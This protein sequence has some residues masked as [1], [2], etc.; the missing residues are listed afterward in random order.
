ML[1]MLRPLATLLFLLGLCAAQ[2]QEICD[3]ALDDDND[4]LIDLNDTTDCSCTGALGGSEEVNSII[5]NP[6]FE[7]LDCCPNALEQLYCA[8]T[9]E[10]ATEPTTDF[11]HECGWSPDVMPQPLPDGLGCV[12]TFFVP[13]WQE[14]VG[15]CLLSPMLAGQ[16]YT[17]QFDVAGTMMDNWVENSDPPNLSETELVLY[18]TTTCPTFPEPG[19]GCPIGIGD[20]QVLASVPYTPAF[21]W[22]QIEMQFTPT[23]EVQAVMLGGPCTLPSDYQWDFASYGPYLLWDDLIM[24]ASDQF[25]SSIAMS[26]S[27]CT[28]DLTLSA[29][30]D[31][32][33]GTYQWFSEGVALVGQVDTVLNLS[34]NGL[35]P[36]T[37]QFQF[38]LDTSCALSTITVPPIP[39]IPP[40]V[41]ASDTVG[42]IPLAVNFSDVTVP[43]VDSCIW[44]FGDNTPSVVGCDVSHTY[45]TPGLYDVTLTIV[46]PD[47]CSYDSTYTDLIHAVGPPTAGFDVSPQPVVV[48]SGI[49]QLSSTSSADA[50]SW[51]W[52][53]GDLPPFGSNIENPEVEVPVVPGAF[54]IT[55][56]VANSYGCIDTVQGMMVVVPS[57]DL[58]MPNVFS[59]NGDTE[60]DRFIPLDD[61]PG[62]ARLTIYNRWGQEIHTTSN[63]AS[64]WNGLIRGS[65]APAGTYYWIVENTGSADSRKFLTGHVT[66]L[67]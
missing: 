59:P 38:T 5:P 47:G 54:P 44:N 58:D 53:F 56:I 7:T 8:D 2:A 63:I 32:L 40:L 15:G 29:H 67:R 62:E 24:N 60:N 50:V 37:Y 66:L 16:D 55:L 41:E 28:G 51:D 33:G 6:S 3:N 35:G 36:G 17:L 42:C 30:P 21:N 61:F 49:A 46:T 13:G 26:G 52:D 23:F 20:W 25:N 22:Q 11:F 65:Q 31:T 12:G 14:Y 9:W 27:L 43:A 1:W 34:T 10:Q 64:G 4:G 45:T 19:Y 57:G 48:G 18:G 39:S